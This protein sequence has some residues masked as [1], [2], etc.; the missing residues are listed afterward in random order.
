MNGNA[1]CFTPHNA[2]LRWNVLMQIKRQLVAPPPL[3]HGKLGLAAAL[4][5]QEE[6]VFALSTLISSGFLRLID[7]VPPPKQ[8]GCCLEVLFQSS[9]GI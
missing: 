5:V 7:A 6:Q 9:S 8:R 3:P 4:P 2:S 1:A